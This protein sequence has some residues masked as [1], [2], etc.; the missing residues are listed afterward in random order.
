MVALSGVLGGLSGKLAKVVD[1]AELKRNVE[2][3]G[4]GGMDGERVNAVG[5]TTG[6]STAGNWR[7]RFKTSWL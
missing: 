2:R 7:D 4:G 5:S 1:M 6:G 3:E